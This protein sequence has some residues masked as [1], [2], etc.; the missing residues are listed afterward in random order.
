MAQS[1]LEKQFAMQIRAKGLPQPEVE[2]RF[3]A[4]LVGAGKGLRKRLDDA[5]LKDWRFDFA[6]L[7]PKL[8]VE[9]NGGNWVRGR[10]TRASA[11][12]SEYAKL[13]AAQ[14]HGW[15]VLTYDGAMVKSG[16]AIRDVADWL[17]RNEKSMHN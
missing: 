12:K 10:H 1:K 2:Y 14:K 11:L 3:C 4:E 5:G 6:W 15:T 13:N 17:N 16:E 9:I 8:A 7:A